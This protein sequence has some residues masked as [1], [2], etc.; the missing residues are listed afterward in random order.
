M[1]Y[2]P[3]M[4]SFLAKYPIVFVIVS[5]I[6]SLLLGTGIVGMTYENDVERL[7]TPMGSPSHKDREALERYFPDHTRDTYYPHQLIHLGTYGELIVR[8]QISE[9]SVLQEHILLEV[10][11]LHQRLLEITLD[12]DD[13]GMT[14]EDLCAERG[15][16]CV[17][18]GL[19]VVEQFLANNNCLNSSGPEPYLYLDNTGYDIDI[20]D[21]LAEVS[22][23][24]HCIQANAIRLRFN[25]KHDTAQQRMLSMHW[26]RKFI[27]ELGQYEAQ[28]IDF[29]YA[30]SESLDIEFADH[31]GKDVKFF[32]LTII[33]MVVYATVV[34]SGGNCVSTR[35]LLAQ[36]GILA[37]LLAILASFGLLSMCGLQFVDIGGVMP[38]LVL[39]TVLVF[40]CLFILKTQLKRLFEINV[41]MS[42]SIL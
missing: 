42:N 16:A 24:N 1:T 29:A 21:V 22:M 3:A 7:Y 20:R 2:S 31:L 40:M 27:E 14:Y 10:K 34:N 13:R 11:D 39:G 35:M 38:F 33:I 41:A 25:L 4:A 17:V 12:S 32:A 5:L 15:D 36:A 8:S 18:D 30:A 26:E 9:E 23:E 6:T 37:A 28:N 19:I